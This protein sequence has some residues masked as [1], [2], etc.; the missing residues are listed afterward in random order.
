[1]GGPTGLLH[2]REKAGLVGEE[3]WVGDS[4][5]GEVRFAEEERGDEGSN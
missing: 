2:G 4:V 5:G 1:M 3:S